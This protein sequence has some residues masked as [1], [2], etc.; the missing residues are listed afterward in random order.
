[1]VEAADVRCDKTLSVHLDLH[2][3]SAFLDDNDQVTGMDALLTQRILTRA[4]C[5]VRWHFTPMTGA[6]ILRSLQQGEF[7]VMVRASKTDA[8]Q[9][10]AYFSEPYRHE[11][12]ALFSRKQLKL[13]A[14]FT[15]AD[16]L[17]QG[18]RLIGPASG[19]YGDEF[20]ALRSKWQKKGFYTA[21]PDAA[22]ATDL[23][24]AEPSRGDLVLVDA[25][26]FF[27]YLGEERYDQI[28]LVGNNVLIT[29]ALLMFSHGSLDQTDLSAIN[30]A[31]VQLRQTGELTAI[32]KSY[33]P[34]GLQK[35]LSLTPSINSS[36]SELW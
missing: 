26:I 8:R 13:P 15:M 36:G 32:E 30:H 31:I 9:Q 11:V 12:V 10:Y 6:R 20:E 19:W 35:L 5:K 29:P 1:M 27:Y 28:N 2:P 33:R 21:Y 18:L 22:R 3:P 17:N 4:G 16:A 25:D 14:A 24:F 7:D 34:L 23:L